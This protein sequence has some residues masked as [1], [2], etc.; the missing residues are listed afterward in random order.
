MKCNTP[1]NKEKLPPCEP[2]QSWELTMARRIKDALD[3]HEEPLVEK[4]L[5]I[6]REKR[7]EVEMSGNMEGTDN[8]VTVYPPPPRHFM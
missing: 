2:M 8:Q 4:L 1:P 7:C 5:A 6:C 3:N